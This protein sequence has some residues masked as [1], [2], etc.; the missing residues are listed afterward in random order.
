MVVIYPANLDSGYLNALYG[1]YKSKLSCKCIQIVRLLLVTQ[2][3]PSTSPTNT[4][5]W[6]NDNNFVCLK[7]QLIPVL[8]LVK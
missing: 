7:K 1:M 2:F 3:K 6:Y 5:D 4:G 8:V